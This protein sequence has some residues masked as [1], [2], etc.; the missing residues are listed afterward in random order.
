MAGVIKVR[1][2]HAETVW[3]QVGKK[4]T[5]VSVKGTNV[6]DF[7]QPP[8]DPNAPNPQQLGYEATGALQAV[9]AVIQKTATVIAMGPVTGAGDGTVVTGGGDFSIAIEGIFTGADNFDGTV[10]TGDLASM[11]AAVVAL[12][13]ITTSQGVVDLTG[14]TISKVDFN[15][16]PLT[17]VI[18]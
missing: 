2:I 14:T 17:P 12:G 8:I 4:L 15:L 16:D 3:E 1:P 6:P 13:S 18:A 7:V 11:E 9:L 10:G 5:W